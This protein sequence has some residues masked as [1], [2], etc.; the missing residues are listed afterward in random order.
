VQA[1]L[2]G[3]CAVGEHL[4]GI[5]V[6]PVQMDAHRPPLAGLRASPHH[7]AVHRHGDGRV[8]DREIDPQ[9]A[10]QLQ[11]TL[12]EDASAVRG[13]VDRRRPEHRPGRAGGRQLPA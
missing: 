10:V 12:G 2:V 3:E 8:A 6:E 1:P 4:L 5:A 11:R 9:A 13:Q 7:A